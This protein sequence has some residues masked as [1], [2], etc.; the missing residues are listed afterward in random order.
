MN[1]ANPFTYGIAVKNK[2]FFDRTNEC[3]RI[4]DTLSSG[5]NLVLYAPRR[6]GKTSLVMRA[7]EELENKGFVCIYFD[8]MRAFSVETFVDF[9]SKAIAAKQSSLQNFFRIFS[10][11]V[12]SI[13]PVLST[14]ELGIPE[15]S[16][17]FTRSVIDVNNL[18]EIL[19]LPQKIANGKKKI[20][21]FFDEFQEIEK[22][23]KFNFEKILRSVVQQQTN[24]NY[25]FLGSK[26]HILKNMFGNKNRAFY[27]SASQMT[28]GYLPEDET[29]TFL[30]NNFAKKE[31]CLS[32][33]TAKYLIDK[34]AKIPH[35][36][37][38]L[39]AE[40]WNLLNIGA[41]AECKHIDDCVLRII[42]MKSDFYLELF[43]NQSNSKKKLLLAITKDGKNI[44]SENYRN[45]YNLPNSSTLQTS[46]KGLLDN[47]IIDK[48]EDVYFICDP[49]FKIFLTS[50]F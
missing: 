15:F 48:K 35:Y 41:I 9:Y 16:I 8:M 45:T 7:I 22:F 39:A 21:V 37:Q 19:E 50:N 4:I 47:G 44:F 32:E 46:V 38:L 20:L 14:N 3:Q 36:I 13:R 30:Q 10:E 17:D 42:E 12:K 29:I 1:I 25:L 26:T 24:V 11:T 49:F 40:L 28:I 5:N 43:I 23:E 33:K 6:F 34:A 31:I 2:N 27:E 18:V